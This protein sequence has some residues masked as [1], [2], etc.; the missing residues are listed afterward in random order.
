MDSIFDLKGSM[1]GRLTKLKGAKNTTVLKDQNIRLKREQKLF[2]IFKKEDR[3][4]IQRI[5][6]RDKDFLAEHNLMDYSLL[7]AVETN[8]G[9]NIQK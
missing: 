6:K 4:N 1:H 2:L 9:V 8:R 3:K 7:F 5:M